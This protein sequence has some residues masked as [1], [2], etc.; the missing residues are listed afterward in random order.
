M[1]ENIIVFV[2][3]MTSTELG[4][5]SHPA[6]RSKIKIETQRRLLVRITFAL[7]DFTPP[8]LLTNKRSMLHH[9]SCHQI[10][11]NKLFSTLLTTIY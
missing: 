1:E 5:S 8:E 9:E 7:S 4:I 2:C 10:Q 11:S 3:T 6:T